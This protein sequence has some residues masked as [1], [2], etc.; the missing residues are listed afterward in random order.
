VENKNAGKKLLQGVNM[1]ILFV[2][3]M[4]TGIALSFLGCKDKQTDAQRFFTPP[5]QKEKVPVKGI[6]HF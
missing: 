6:D 1:K 2:V 5:P 3:I 4:I